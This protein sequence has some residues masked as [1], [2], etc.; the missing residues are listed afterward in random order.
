MNEHTSSIVCFVFELIIWS[1]FFFNDGQTVS[2][3][4]IAVTVKLCEINISAVLEQW[5]WQNKMFICSNL[6]CCYPLF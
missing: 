6:T 1:V 2:Q 4:G 3:V 5:Y